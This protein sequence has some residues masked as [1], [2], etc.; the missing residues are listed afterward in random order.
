MEEWQKEEEDHVAVSVA[1]FVA[2]FEG[3][4]VENWGANQ[5]ADYHHLH[6]KFE[7]TLVEGHHRAVS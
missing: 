5:G 1:T 3:E 6:Q 2:E 4:V 7:A